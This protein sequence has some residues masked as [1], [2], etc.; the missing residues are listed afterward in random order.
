M[1]PLLQ[2]LLLL[3]LA[4]AA[5]QAATIDE[6]SGQVSVRRK[7]SP[8]CGEQ[9]PESIRALFPNFLSQ[10]DVEWL[11]EIVKEGMSVIE[12]QNG[13]TIMDP[14][15]GLV[16]GPGAKVKKVRHKFSED[17]LERYG[18]MLRKVYHKVLEVHGLPE[19]VL[20]H[21]SPTFIAQLKPFPSGV[22]SKHIHDE[23]KST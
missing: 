15:L 5:A 13:P 16:L 2:R 22:V 11:K 6:L 23:C 10:E 8:A 4:L 19:D 14:D 17:A 3:I 9:S 12:D 21:T 20:Y 7:S 1:C 18:A